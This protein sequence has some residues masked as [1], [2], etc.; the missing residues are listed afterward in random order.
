MLSPVVE[1]A[2]AP[3]GE[4]EDPLMAYPE[5]GYWALAPGARLRMLRALC[6]DALDTAVI[7]CL[8][9]FLCLSALACLYVCVRKQLTLQLSCLPKDRILAVLMPTLIAGKELMT[10]LTL[11]L[12][13]KRRPGRRLRLP[14]GGLPDYR[15]MYVMIREQTIAAVHIVV[16]TSTAGNAEVWLM[17]IGSHVL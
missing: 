17:Q 15:T 7:R 12:L 11:R 4:R 10:A 9:S 3:E 1:A 16:S 6:C 8:L 5:G 13:R 2:E 14:E